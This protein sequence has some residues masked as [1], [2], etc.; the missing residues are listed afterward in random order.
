MSVPKF[1]PTPLISRDGRI[2][3]SAM[4]ACNTC[5]DQGPV[6]TTDGACLPCWRMLQAFRRAIAEAA[7]DRGKLTY[8]K[9]EVSR[10]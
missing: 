7:G 2:D 4:P 5:G 10:G 6:D 8:P 3:W 9:P 1:T